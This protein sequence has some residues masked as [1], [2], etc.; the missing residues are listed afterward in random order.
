MSEDLTLEL[1]YKG[2]ELSLPI[3]LIRWG[4]IYRL[5]VTINDTPVI[6]ERDEERN[7][8]AIIEETVSHH[9]QP[10]VALLQAISKEIERSLE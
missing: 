2:K 6:F 8:R 9:K 10:D 4:Y 5:Q 3:Q 7:W 1:S